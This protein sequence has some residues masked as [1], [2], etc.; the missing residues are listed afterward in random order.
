MHP[1]PAAT[2]P[3]FRDAQSTG[4]D[5][6]SILPRPEGSIKRSTQIS[7]PAALLGHDHAGRGPLQQDRTASAQTSVR[8]RAS[9][10]PATN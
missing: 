2:D 9:D 4:S 10:H 3:A 8:Q 6:N 5:P 1:P 7:V